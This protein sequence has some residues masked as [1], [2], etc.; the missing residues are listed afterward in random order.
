MEALN[1]VKD[2]TKAVFKVRIN[3]LITP[4]TTEK[5]KKE[6]KQIRLHTPV[7]LAAVINSQG[8]SAS[9]SNIIREELLAYAEKKGIKLYCFAEDFAA[10]GGYL[11]LSAGNE[12]Y[13]AQGSLLGCIGAGFNF[14]EVKQLADSYGIKRRQWSTSEKDLDLRLDPLNPLSAEA[15]IWAKDIL[16]QS[17]EQL[18]ILIS[19]SRG[20]KLVKQKAFTGDLFNGSEAKDLG[21][22]DNLGTCEQIMSTLYPKAKILEL[23]KR[24]FGPF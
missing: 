6:L 5:L 20:E 11:I 15:K 16:N 19:H 2:L 21:L 22:I 12:V 18:Q 3:G 8:G 17:T 1:R 24:R 4:A 7:A 23:T 13:S 10:S 14:F 9:Q